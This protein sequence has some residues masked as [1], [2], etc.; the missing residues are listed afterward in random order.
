MRQLL[1]EGPQPRPGDRVVQP[2][3]YYNGLQPEFGPRSPFSKV[4]SLVFEPRIPIR[5]MHPA[6]ASFYAMYSKRA[7]DLPG[8][9]Y[10]LLPNYPLERFDIYVRR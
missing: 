7:H 5:A 6:G 10:R 1:A 4:D 2:S 9:P 8:L 3:N